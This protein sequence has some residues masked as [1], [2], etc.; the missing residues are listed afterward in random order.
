MSKQTKT[1]RELIYNKIIE[2][3]TCGKISP[4]EKLNERKIA[5]EFHVSRTPVREAFAQLEKAGAIVSHSNAGAVVRR[6]TI[7]QIEEILDIISVLEGYAIEI[8]VAKGIGEGDLKQMEKL[9]KEMEADEERKDYFKFE[10]TNRKFHDFIVQK[11]GNE[12]LENI[13]GDLTRKVYVGGLTLPFSIHE[14]SKEHKKII[15]AILERRPREASQAM[16]LH[17]QNVKKKKVEML[18]KLRG[19]RYL[20]F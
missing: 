17:T 5:K 6:L 20:N 2:G 11:A 19:N 12:T 18:W 3:I 9:E 14:Y 8:A 15:K 1:L 4:G 7:E 10:E 16:R 13:V